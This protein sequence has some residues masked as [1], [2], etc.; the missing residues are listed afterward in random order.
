MDGRQLPKQGDPQ[1]F[2]YGYSVGRW[3]GD[4][5]VVVRLQPDPAPYRRSS[6][7]FTAF[8]IA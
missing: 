5:L 6:A 1:P 7:R 3:E 4:T 2:W 8:A